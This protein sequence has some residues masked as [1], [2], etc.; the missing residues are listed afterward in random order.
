MDVCGR[1]WWVKLFR[2]NVYVITLCTLGTT[3]VV[4]GVLT[5]NMIRSAVN[6]IIHC[7]FTHIC[8]IVDSSSC[9]CLIQLCVSHTA[10]C[11]HTAVC[12]LIQLCVS[13]T[14]VC[15]SYSC[16]CLIQLCLSH[17]AVCV[18]YSCV[19]LIQLCV[20]VV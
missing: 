12:V 5:M 11:A 2:A 8:C 1:V 15:V 9:V 14:A 4:W 7:L 3:C 16:V 19:C 20:C 6:M 10:V 18:S 17:T 13:H